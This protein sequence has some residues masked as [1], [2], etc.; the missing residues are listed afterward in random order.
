MG[1]QGRRWMAQAG[2]CMVLVGASTVAARA[3]EDGAFGQQQNSGRQGSDGERRG[4]GVRGTVVA[5]SGAN[6]TIKTEQ[7]DSWTVITTNNTRLNLDQQTVKVA[8]LKAG[9]EVMAMGIP[10]AAKHEIHAMMVMGAS[11]A[12]VAK[13]KADLGKTFIVGRVTAINDTNVTVLRPDKV[14]QTIALDESTSLRRGGHMPAEAMMSGMGAGGRRRD[15]RR[16]GDGGSGTNGTPN[17]TSGGG[18]PAPGSEGEAITLADVKVGDS[19]GGSGTLKNGTFVPTEL[20][21]MRSRG[22]RNGPSSSTGTS[23]AQ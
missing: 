7:G 20:H 15:G 3:Q 22:S 17:A 4:R 21:V 10:D 14:S 23:P 2:L 1:N 6:V 9:D 18:E 13:M 12:Q 16:E 19:V 11:A 8:D 5:A